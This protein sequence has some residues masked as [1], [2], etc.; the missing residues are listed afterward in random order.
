M[1]ITITTSLQSLITTVIRPSGIQALLSINFNFALINSTYSHKGWIYNIK[2]APVVVY[3]LQTSGSDA[4][5]NVK[6][7]GWKTS[8][9]LVNSWLGIVGT[10]G[11]GGFIDQYLNTLSIPS[12][13]LSVPAGITLSGLGHQSFNNFDLIY[14]NAQ[15][16]SPPYILCADNSKC[17]LLTTCCNWSG[18]YGCCTLPNANCCQQGGCCYSQCQCDQNG[19]CDC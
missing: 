14:S 7:T 16:K 15:Y 1:N 13:S 17:P 8:V 2:D 5:F 10:D 3:S 12:E 4:T 18:S 9:N 11:V 6:L 19:G